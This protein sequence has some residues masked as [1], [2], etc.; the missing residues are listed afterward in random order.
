MDEHEVE[1]SPVL[2]FVVCASKGGPYEDDAYVAGYEAAQ[3]DSVLE[4]LAVGSDVTVTVHAPNLPQI[5][6]VAMRRGCAAKVTGE[7]VDG[8]VSITYTKSAGALSA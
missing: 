6:L 5:E 8:W 4:R 1:W 2:P 3:I 7:E